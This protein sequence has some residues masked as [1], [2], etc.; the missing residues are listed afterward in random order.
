[1]SR[2][3]P[4]S[5]SEASTAGSARAGT[6]ARVSHPTPSARETAAASG[7]VTA[8]SWATAG[9]PWRGR[10]PRTSGGAARAG[11]PRGGRRGG[12]DG[13]AERGRATL[14]AASG[15]ECLL[16][17]AA[18]SGQQK[19]AAMPPY[20]QR[21]GGGDQPGRDRARHDPRTPRSTYQCRR[22]CDP[23]RLADT[24]HVRT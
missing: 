16:E 8:R 17:L 2:G 3:I 7:R 1:C 5:Y 18:V 21:A 23:L 6:S 15:F 4:R 10:W 9:G 19:L 11:T 13:D 20:D 14:A 22:D 24:E 12:R